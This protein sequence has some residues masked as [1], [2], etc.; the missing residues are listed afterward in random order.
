MITTYIVNM[1]NY[2]YM[3]HTQHRLFDVCFSLWHAWLRQHYMPEKT[4]L[5]YTKYTYIVMHG[6]IA[7][8]VQGIILSLAV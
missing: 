7:Y 8:L 1:C 5:I 3:Y 6:Q 2:V 4:V